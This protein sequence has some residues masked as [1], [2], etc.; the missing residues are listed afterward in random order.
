MRI[1]ADVVIRRKGDNWNSGWTV[2]VNG[3]DMA[4]QIADLE[5]TWPDRGQGP[6]HV[7]MTLMANVDLDLPE[8][9]VEV[10]A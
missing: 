3:E 1:E 9:E 6:A 7:T 8:S 5:V 10:R 2:V 4:N